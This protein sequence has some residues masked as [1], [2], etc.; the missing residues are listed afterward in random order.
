[1]KTRKIIFSIAAAL[2]VSGFVTAQSSENGKVYTQEQ[3]N[4]SASKSAADKEKAVKFTEAPAGAA[5]P[6]TTTSVRS[7]NVAAH[8]TSKK[9]P[10]LVNTTR[11][12]QPRAERKTGTIQ[13]RDDIERMKAANRSA[14]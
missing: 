12:V 3:I 10:N 6:A 2:L 14:K 4:R 9:A 11:T 13:T 1:M 8:T 5:K 7:K